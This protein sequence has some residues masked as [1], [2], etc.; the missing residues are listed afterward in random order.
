MFGSLEPQLAV[1]RTFNLIRTASER[2]FSV[3]RVDTH[4]LQV[5]HTTQDANFIA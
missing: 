1:L 2:D 3:C 5:M 4:A